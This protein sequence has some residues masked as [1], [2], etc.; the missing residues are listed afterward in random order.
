MKCSERVQSVSRTYSD[1]IQKVFMKCSESVQGGKFLYLGTFPACAHLPGRAAV[2][3]P[4]LP[5]GTDSWRFRL[6]TP[7]RSLTGT[8]RGPI[9]ASRTP[10]VGAGGAS[11]GAL[12]WGRMSSRGAKWGPS[13]G[14]RRG[15]GA[16]PSRARAAPRNSCR[17]L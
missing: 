6:R 9:G 2:R 7:F 13:E 14:G 8:H 5:S 16:F 10:G 11:R 3:G 15:I 17:S 12:G 1:G 4:R